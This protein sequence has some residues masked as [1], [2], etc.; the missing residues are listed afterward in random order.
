MKA[1]ICYFSGT[2]NTKKVVDEYK[3]TLDGKGIET[4]L[5][6]IDSLPE[7]SFEGADLVGFAYP[8]HA[9]NAPSNVLEFAKK[10]KK[11]KSKVNY[12]VIKTSGEPLAINN[13]SSYKLKSILKKRNFV[14]TNEYHYVM[15]YNMIFRQTDKMAYDMWEAAKQ[16]NT[17]DCNEI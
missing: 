11:Q 10:I 7:V 14:L 9:F 17:I 13:I 4:T 6:N 15:P 1:I 16:V 2:G 3:K 8:I 5:V 12:F